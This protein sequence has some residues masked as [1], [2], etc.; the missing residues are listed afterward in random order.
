MGRRELRAELQSTW[1][2]Y[3]P[4]KPGVPFRK[5][6]LADA[7]EALQRAESAGEPPPPERGAVMPRRMRPRPVDEYL[8]GEHIGGSE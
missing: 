1:C 3:T 6:D 8:D 5:R 2:V 4:A 7:S